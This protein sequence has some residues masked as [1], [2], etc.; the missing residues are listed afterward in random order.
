MKKVLA[1]VVVL[2]MSAVATQADLMT[3]NGPNSDTVGVDGTK[4][5]NGGVSDPW[6]FSLTAYDSPIVIK[7][8][9]IGM[10]DENGGA[11]VGEGNNPVLEETDLKQVIDTGGRVLFDITYNDT[12][13]GDSFDET[14]IDDLELR[15]LAGRTSETQVKWAAGWYDLP[16]LTISAGSTIYFNF[17]RDLAE[18]GGML[19]TTYGQDTSKTIYADEETQTGPILGY[20]SLTTGSS[21]RGGIWQ[22]EY[23]VVPEPATMAMLG[24]GGLVALRRRRR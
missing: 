24:L 16:D 4:L 19:E 22:F 3:I 21:G 11:N 6:Q 13:V 7:S 18:S 15:E 1:I 14:W 9:W 2:A 20:N 5:K 8:A 23:E 12:G 10:N 17:Q